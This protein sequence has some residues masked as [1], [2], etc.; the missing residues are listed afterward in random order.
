MNYFVVTD[1]LKGVQCFNLSKGADYLGNTAY[2][3]NERAINSSD[4]YF[5]PADVFKDY[6]DALAAFCNRCASKLTR[7]KSGIAA[8]EQ[9]KNQV[10]ES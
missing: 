4:R 8:I 5:L 10:L 2:Y 7:L 6:D 1:L 9:V 3:V